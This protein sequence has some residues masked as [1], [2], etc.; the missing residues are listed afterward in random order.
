MKKIEIL[1]KTIGGISVKKCLGGNPIKYLCVC[2]CGR[3]FIAT[4]QRIRGGNTDCGC[5]CVSG[6]RR[7]KFE[8]GDVYKGSRVIGVLKKYEQTSYQFICAG[9]G[10]EA[11]R[12]HAVFLERPLCSE[13]LSR[14]NKDEKIEI[15]KEKY[16]G[17]ILNGI[18]IISVVGYDQNH[19]GHS[20]VV[21]AVC[22]ICS[23]TF[24]TYVSRIK[25]GL[26]SC[27]DCAMK[28]L[29]KGREISLKM[30]VAGTNVSSIS[31][32]RR[33]NKNS[34]TGHTG[35]SVDGKSGRYRAYINFRRKQYYL[36]MY[37]KIEDAIK[38]RK[39]AEKEI[40]GD[41]LDWYAKEH[42]EEWERMEKKRNAER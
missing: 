23:N 31:G 30:C 26:K 22:P 11:E 12:V 13:C 24:E 36:G 15:S 2:K 3:E 16:E 5:G 1:G 10:K 41:F 17:K 20:L 42:P 37:D 40:Y 39:A 4:S 14:Q 18:K 21:K 34:S 33:V 6:Q 35:V 27:A 7:K 38:A 9:C 32:T 19:I 8:I 29:D 25:Q 28:N